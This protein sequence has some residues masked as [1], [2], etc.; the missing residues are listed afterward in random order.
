[1]HAEVIQAQP[2]QEKSHPSKEQFKARLTQ[3]IYPFTR[4]YRDVYA[5]VCVVC[6]TP[7]PAPN[8]DAVILCKSIFL[9]SVLLIPPLY[10]CT[11]TGLVPVML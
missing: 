8:R 3:E 9:E 11:V 7:L 1:M 10:D 2:L 4:T 5:C 6:R